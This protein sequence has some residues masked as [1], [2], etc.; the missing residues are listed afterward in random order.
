MD[1]ILGSRTYVNEGGKVLLAGDSAGQQYTSQRRADQLYD[2]KGEIAC[3][4]PPAGIGPAA[5]PAVVGL[6]R[7]W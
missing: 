3:N 4:P 6:V 2:P 7:R 5:L 1:E